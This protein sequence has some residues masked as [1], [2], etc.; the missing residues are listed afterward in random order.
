MAGTSS[1]RF[2]T[3]A[4]PYANGSL[5]F[6]HLAGVYLPADIYTRHSKLCGKDTLYI[7][8]SDEHGVAICLKAEQTKTPYQEYVDH[9]YHDHQDLFR[10]YDIEF[11]F[12]G[13]TSAEYHKERAK[14][15]FLRVHQSG[16]LV[17]NTETQF[18]CLKDQMYLAD[19]YLRGRC[20]HCGYEEAR[21]DECPNCGVWLSSEDLKD[22]RC[23]VCGGSELENREV[24]HWYFDLP[25][26]APRIE[27]WLKE[28][29]AW[30]ENV[31][32]YA[33]SLLKDI[34]Q[35][36]VTRNVSWG[37][38]LPEPFYEEGKKIYVWFEAPV[39]YLSNLQEY[40][41][42]KGD[43]DGWEEY[44]K[45]SEM[46]HFIGKDNI[47]FHTIIWPAML[48]AIGERLPTNVPSNMFLNFQK[49]Q[50]SKSSGTFVDAKKVLHDYGIDRLRY[51][52]VTIMPE[53]QDSTFD[54][55]SF[56]DRVNGELVNK[57]AN[58]F[59]R[60]SSQI[61][62]QYE[63]RLDP[64][65]FGQIESLSSWH[66]IVDK[67]IEAFHLNAGLQEIVGLTEEANKY[68]DNEKPWKL[69]KEDK[70]KAKPVFAKAANYMISIAS[71]LQPYLPSYAFRVLEGFGMPKDFSLRGDLYQ[72]G[73]FN[74]LRERGLQ[75]QLDADFTV[76]RITQEQVQKEI[77]R[78]SS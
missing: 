5:H 17:E 70:E 53:F 72:E 26:L 42:Q 32:N 43:P 58:L 35:R 14:E 30:K 49:K 74:M 40:F 12:Y 24:R 59:N 50:F 41:R 37:V 75:I 28:Q 67:H 23:A 10:L 7:C 36:A 57:I 11:S 63:G 65:D 8:G 9:W 38:D 22:P 1:K 45:D 29:T 46:I 31:K 2:I 20:G 6:G 66:H 68:L 34:P 56:H 27:A 51:Y 76:S 25:R 52:L 61:K 4:L 21:G 73:G 64:E 62:K 69:V 13:K 71:L 44:W 77:E 78:Y 39:G 54:W 47:I 16:Y 3:A 19:R 48:L 33:L 60:V 55:Q 15:F 18:Y